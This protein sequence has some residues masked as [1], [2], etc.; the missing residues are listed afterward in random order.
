MSQARAVID[1]PTVLPKGVTKRQWRLAA[2]LPSCETAAEALR[3]AGYSPATVRNNGYRQVA[4]GGVK[5]ATLAIQESQADKARGLLAVGKLALSTVSEDLKS[6]EPR[7]RIAAGFKA[8]ELASTL[9]E[10][11]ELSGSAGAWKHR[12]MRACRL[13]AHLTALRLASPPPVQAAAAERHAR[14]VQQRGY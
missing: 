9:G 10:N 3:L 7:D 1:V 8:H 2:L 4:L 5:R 6:L 11:L 13:T 14:R 12:L